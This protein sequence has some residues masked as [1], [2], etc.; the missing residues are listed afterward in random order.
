MTYKEIAME[1]G[2]MEVTIQTHVKRAYKF[3]RE[4]MSMCWFA[5]LSDLFKF[6]F[7]FLSLIFFRSCYLL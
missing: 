5:L 4:S 6:F 1:L 2:L 3:I 7:I